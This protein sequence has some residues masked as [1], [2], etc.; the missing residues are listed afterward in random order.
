MIHCRY[1][2]SP[3]FRKEFTVDKKIA[4]ARV[5]VTSHGYYELH[6]NGKK[7]GDQVLTPGWT[8]YSKRLQY[9][10]YD[11]TEMLQTGNNAIGAVLGDGWY[12]GTLAMGKTGQFMAKDSDF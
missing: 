10:V 4:S 11:V 9:Q 2:P 5:Y 3:H 12:R 6:L 7:V 8:S 1:S